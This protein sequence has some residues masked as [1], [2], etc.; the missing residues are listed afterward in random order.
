MEE[1]ELHL[2]PEKIKKYCDINNLEEKQ[3]RC[4]EIWSKYLS[5]NG[6]LNNLHTII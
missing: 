4:K 1:K 5:P 3:N 2:L 6:F